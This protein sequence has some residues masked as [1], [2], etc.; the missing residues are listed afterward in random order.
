MSKRLIE[1]VFKKVEEEIGASKKTQRAQYLSD[2]L[3]DNHKYPISERRLRD[4]FTSYIEKEEE[5]YEAL[6]PQ[7]IEALCK[8]L[9]YDNYAS[10]VADYPS[11]IKATP[12]KLDKN[13]SLIEEKKTVR[14]GFLHSYK[15]KIVI[16]SSV[17]AIS[18][19]TYFGFVK[20]EQN[21]MIWKNNQY[22]RCVCSGVSLE[23]P[24]DEIT[25]KKFR[26]ITQ[27][28]SLLERRALEKEL[29]YDK[30]NGKV[31]FFSYH[32]YHPENEKALKNVTDYIFKAYVLDR[33]NT[34]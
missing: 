8:Y 1:L 34:K 32:G 27:V 31:E 26:R 22:E 21:C 12:E 33:K 25:L 19:L 4:Y 29:W 10:F 16:T 23:K 7:L 18:S 24:L 20:E 3:L 2:V 28:D 30:S 6:K 15:N 13:K 11:E 14:K 9:G 5:V 17:I